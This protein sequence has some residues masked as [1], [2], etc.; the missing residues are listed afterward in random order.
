M[1][2]RA[3][4]FV[5]RKKELIRAEAAIE[6]A[7]A[8]D[9]A[10][11]LLS[12]EAGIGKTRIAQTIA[13]SSAVKGA[14]VAWGRAWEAGG[15]PPFWPWVQIFRALGMVEDPFAADDRA[16]GDSLPHA[17]FAK[18]DRAAR[19]L[20]Q[21]AFDGPLVLVLDDL[22]AADLS[23]LL[24]LQFL[25]TDLAGAQV[26]VLGAYR[27]VEARLA[28]DVGAILP[29]IAREAETLA[30][31]RL[32]E[33]E[34]CAWIRAAE[35]GPAESIADVAKR[36]YRVS[37][38]NP[39]FVHELLRVRGT[40]V[41]DATTA[42]GLRAVL[43]AHLARVSADTRAVLEIGA[44]LGRDLDP[45]LIVSMSDLS[46]DDVHRALHEAHD[47]G[48]LAFIGD[49]D[50]LS[51]EHILVRE[52]LYADLAPSKRARLHSAAAEAVLARGGN[53]ATATHHLLESA[54]APER[55]AE[56]ACDAARAA[57]NM[58]AFEDAAALCERA[59]A[60]HA[61]DDAI[62]FELELLL[63]ESRIRVGKT[64][65][66]KSSCSRAASRAKRMGCP[67]RQ[68]Q[69]A[70]VYAL[71]FV[72]EAGTTVALLRD[73]LEALPEDA[74][75][76]R[77]RTL[78]RY[79]L[80]IAPG[81]SADGALQ[82]IRDA[83]AAIDM[84][85]RCGDVDTLLYAL[86]YG[87]SGTRYLTPSR[88]TH[89][90]VRELMAMAE[91]L[92]RPLLSLDVGSGWIT[93]LREHATLTEADAALAKYDR[94]IEELDVPQ[95]RWRIAMLRST[96]AALA[97][98]FILADQL[99]ADARELAK[100]SGL[101][102]EGDLAWAMARLSFALLRGEPERIATDN[103]L[104]QAIMSSI[105]GAP[106]YAPATNLAVGAFIC[107]AIGRADDARALLKQTE[108]WFWNYHICVSAAEASVILGDAEWAERLYSTLVAH[109]ANNTFI[110]EPF[111]MLAFGPTQRVAGD[112]A[113]LL[114]KKDDA[115]RLY[116]EAIAIG[117]RMA[118][119]A[120]IELATK[121]K[122]ALG[123][124]PEVPPG[125]RRSAVSP[126]AVPIGSGL[127]GAADRLHVARDGEMWRIIS[128]TGASLHLKDSKGL[129]YLAELVSDPGREFH[130]TQLVALGHAPGDTGAV[131]DVRAKQQYRQRLESLR[132]QLE[133]ARRFSDV[134][135]AD[136]I[137][138]EMDLLADELARAVGLG[139]R[140]RKLGSHVER[141]RINV[142][143][144]LRD[145][146]ERIGHHDPSLGRY[147]S[148]TVKTGLYCVFSPV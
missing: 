4:P 32:S 91:A 42:L 78:A 109:A 76:M 102:V 38:G 67:T 17:R 122:A 60:K 65:E 144:R 57:R 24:F 138:A 83:D 66:G 69:A 44:V 15:A 119:P 5:G 79:A 29:K 117:Q 143:R 1:I 51:F 43:E 87:A 104:I 49:A 36:I 124:D 108:G 88:K 135:R 8:G 95:Y 94:L 74:S 7:L 50:R 64:T 56:V 27:E 112:V 129:Q 20:K 120:L 139:G 46:L 26:L 22:H 127:H 75:P 126:S 142:Q 37:E 114:G 101:L 47:A 115:R 116:D 137:E 61:A 71:D 73:A 18:F 130:V 34:V 77:A 11:L 121:R 33:D 6:H 31:G 39:L 10:L 35:A 141:L 41:T 14:R 21:T 12:G 81:A 30:L 85:R 107:A 45:A 147:L 148:A 93:L 133:E 90:Q 97:G 136:A 72:R 82:I 3:E 110:W 2:G 98:D 40:T 53:L 70:L 128:P 55:I 63:A 118:A 96:W 28:P 16:G 25:S 54:S 59:L 134:S 132:D 58:L 84:A 99:C 86:H 113:R 146:I 89:E 80:S 48:L 19:W 103:E 92:D 68:A 62:T 140:D 9:G 23:S 123:L 111:G 100:R 131:L 145:A 106:N 125:S 13:Q 52:R 105:S